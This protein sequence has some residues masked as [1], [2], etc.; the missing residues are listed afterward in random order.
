MAPLVAHCH[1][2]VGRVY[3]RAGDRPKIAAH[4]TAAH[5]L[6]AETLRSE[7]AG[8]RPVDA[9]GATVEASRTA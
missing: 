4:L 5:V 1:L 6:Y 2:G 7:L 9:L 8:I 3:R